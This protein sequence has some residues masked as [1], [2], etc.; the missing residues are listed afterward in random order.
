MNFY[1]SRP[2]A[3]MDATTIF[4]VD[5]KLISLEDKNCTTLISKKLVTCTTV[6]SC[7]KYNGLNL[8]TSLD[9]EVSW[10]LDSKKQRSPR[11]FFYN[12]EGKNIR[13]STMRLYRGKSECKTEK[14]Y[15]SDVIRDK[16]TPLEVEMRYNL[17]EVTTSYGS[18]TVPR[19]K[20][21]NLDPI[22]DQNLGTI[23]KDSINIQKNC[24]PDNVCIPDLKLEIK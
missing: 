10:V 24:G 6:R 21:G 16:L 17:R 9:I 18:T 22:L 14:V 4:G 12:E 13:N 23:R 2:V 3:S 15:I 11:L 5:N 8:P 20:R 1:R 7:L 19:R